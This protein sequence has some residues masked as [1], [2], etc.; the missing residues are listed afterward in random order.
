MN[1][2]CS[3]GHG[4]GHRWRRLVG[5]APGPPAVGTGNKTLDRGINMAIML[6]ASTYALTKLLTV[7]FQD[8]WHGW[9]IFE[10]LRYMPEHTR[11]L[12]RPTRF[13]P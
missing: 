8:Y 4:W 10:I 6:G 5:R 7:V 12:S 2:F 11:R 13:W 9:T 1:Y 3:S